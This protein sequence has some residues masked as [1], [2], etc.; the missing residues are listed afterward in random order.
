MN[1]NKNTKNPLIHLLAL[2]LI[3]FALL[4]TDSINNL[5]Q[6]ILYGSPG[7][8]QIIIETEDT[9][10]IDFDTELVI[11]RKNEHVDMPNEDFEENHIDEHEIDADESSYPPSV[12]DKDYSYAHG[13][14]YDF[15]IGDERT[16][17]DELVES[18]ETLSSSTS[19]TPVS[20]IQ[21]TD[22]CDALRYDHPEFYWLHNG[23]PYYLD[24][25][26][27]VVRADNPI[28]SDALEK[29]G[30]FNS[31]ASDICRKT[32][33]LS[34]YDIYKY[35]YDYIIDQTSYGQA[36]GI[37]DQSLSGVFENHLAVCAG[38]SDAFKFLC[39]RAGLF[40]ITVIG[41]GYGNDTIN[42]GYH[43]WNLIMIDDEYS[44]VDVTW[45]DCCVEK[46][47][48]IYENPTRYLYL[49]VPDDYFLKRHTISY[50][51]NSCSSEHFNASYPYCNNKRFC[52]FDMTGLSFFS[53]EEAQPYILN[54]LSEGIPYVR[55]KFSSSYELE[56][57]YD[58]LNNQQA[59]W[60]LA[61]QSGRSYSTC[62][63][64]IDHDFDILVFEFI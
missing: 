12:M 20:E 33:G 39:D 6:N 34:K 46:G 15:L 3:L 21:F 38:Y 55:M 4:K 63:S 5:I 53:Y 27:N 40:C 29:L 60:T 2:V 64:Y 13:Y 57:A 31:I 41:T 32:A 25:A 23:L 37:D 61:D 51:L 59:I 16:V 1:S 30:Q 10:N 18:C 52:Y 47:S 22:V 43:A 17:Y 9:G 35:I 62:Y 11:T 36:I 14:Y 19:I 45:G 24:N 42:G 56:R 50:N 8:G 28:P 54:T 7:A 26:G 49:C 44:W 48:F 58:I